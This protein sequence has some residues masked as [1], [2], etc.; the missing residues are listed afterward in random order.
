MPGGFAHHADGSSGKRF[1]EHDAGCAS[2]N[3]GFDGGSNFVRGTA[4]VRGEDEPLAVAFVAG[5]LDNSDRA[6]GSFG[7]GRVVEVRIKVFVFL[8]E[9]KQRAVGNF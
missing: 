7:D 2:I 8:H 5:A 1:A 9:E 6:A 4:D 3:N